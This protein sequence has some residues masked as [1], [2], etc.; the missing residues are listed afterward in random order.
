MN[1]HVTNLESQLK[2]TGNSQVAQEL[3]VAAAVVGITDFTGIV[4]HVWVSVKAASVYVTFDGTDP[5]T[6][7]AVGILLAN[8]YNGIWSRA[9]ANVA[10]FI[11]G[12]GDATV[13]FEPLSE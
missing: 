12:S 1:V 13:R 4:T 6:A 8:G 2:P 3:D 11:K 5:D 10:K 9:L 7:T